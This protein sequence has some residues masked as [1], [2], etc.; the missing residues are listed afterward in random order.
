M[1]RGVVLSLCAL[2]VLLSRENFPLL[3]A[4]T[5]A[6]ARVH[7]MKPNFKKLLTIAIA[8]ST[9][10]AIH[11]ADKSSQG[12][13]SGQARQSSPS[14]SEQSDSASQ[15][16][17]ESSGQQ[18]SLNQLPQAV[19]KTM[20][21][22]S[23]GANVE[24]IRESNRNGQP[25]Y[26]A[27]FDRGALKGTM[28]VGQ[29]GSLMSLQESADFAVG[30]ELP[31]LEKNKIAF[32]QLPQPVQETI[33]Q[34]AG[35]AQLGD[36]SKSE[37]NG[38]QLYRAE[39]N[40]EG[41]H[42]ELFVSKDGKIASQVQETAFAIAPMQQVRSLDLKDT[43]RAVQKSVRRDV[44]GARVTD[45]DQAQWNGQTVYSVMVDKNGRL[46]QY[47]FGQ[48]GKVLSE[49]GRSISEAAG[50]DNSSKQQNQ[51]GQQQ[52]PQDQQNQ[53]SSSQSDQQKSDQGQNQQ[54]K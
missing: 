35:S 39:F 41:I 52:Q 4:A 36:L 54:P 37:V 44:A 14:Q 38:Q 42:H 9:A 23:G 19:Q 1:E 50:A 43:P 8:G 51:G 29:N 32:D 20:T 31:K 27:T 25:C 53:N 6:G 18:L 17:S 40:H 30:I 47:I 24:N 16:K 33:K 10:I 12:S 3:I 48:D 34:Q 22:H 5:A 7:Y 15:N 21:E 13:A 26:T 46:S 28:T 49:P 45:V 11:A 2:R